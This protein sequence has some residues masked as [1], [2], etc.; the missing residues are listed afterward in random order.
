MNQTTK[1][2]I[3]TKIVENVAKLARIRASEQDKQFWVGELNAILQWIEQLNDV[4]TQGIEPLS[5]VVDE[6][7]SLRDD[8][9]TDGHDQA[10]V[11]KNAPSASHGFFTVPKVVE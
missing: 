2:S 8:R 4:D 11:L 6:T 3:T 5:S 10:G 1:A 9:V 7:L